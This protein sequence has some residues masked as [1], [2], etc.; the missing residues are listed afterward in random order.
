L[1]TNAGNPLVAVL[2]L[3]SAGLEFAPTGTAI[4]G[5]SAF[6]SSLMSALTE[7]V[8]ATEA[9]R[10]LEARYT[11]PALTKD[12]VIQTIRVALAVKEQ[13]VLVD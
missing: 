12:V 3:L 5:T 11:H 10:N 8:D 7:Q 6:T 9:A 13:E 2:S 4:F 1:D